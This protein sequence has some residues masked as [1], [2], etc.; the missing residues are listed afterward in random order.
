[1]ESSNRQVSKITYTD[2]LNKGA[3]L[4]L[5]SDCGYSIFHC[6]TKKKSSVKQNCRLRTKI[7]EKVARTYLRE[8]PQVQLLV[9]AH[10]LLALV[11]VPGTPVGGVEKRMGE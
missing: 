3:Q 7:A 4:R 1:M 8:F 5:P 2:L 6:R 11:A 9:R 10:V